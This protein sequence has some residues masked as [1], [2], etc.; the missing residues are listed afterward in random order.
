MPD[1]IDIN[2]MV[3][4]PECGY[5][6]RRDRVTVQQALPVLIDFLRI[7]SV[8]EVLHPDLEFGMPMQDLLDAS[9]KKLNSHL[10]PTSN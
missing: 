5:D 7:T 1:T 8:A 4:C 9:L 6:P 2:L 10:N 3:K